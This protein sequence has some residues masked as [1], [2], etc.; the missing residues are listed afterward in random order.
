MEHIGQRTGEDVKCFSSLNELIN[1]FTIQDRS[2]A[3]LQ[4]KLDSGYA[5]EFIETTIEDGVASAAYNVDD[6]DGYVDDADNLG[7]GNYKYSAFVIG[8]QKMSDGR[9]IARINLD[10]RFDVTLEYDFINETESYWD[11]EDRAYLW[12]VRTY[13]TASFEAEASISFTMWIDKDGGVEFND[14]IEV[15]TD[16][17]VYDTDIIEVISSEDRDGN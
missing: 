5:K 15:P 14:Y 17:E 6:P 1:F 9:S 11:K 3:D 16:I 2:A 4:E 13:R 7:T 8:L 10:T 12:K